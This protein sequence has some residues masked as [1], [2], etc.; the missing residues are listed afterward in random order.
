[1]TPWNLIAQ[2]QKPNQSIQPKLY[3]NVQNFTFTYLIGGVGIGLFLSVIFI[4]RRRRVTG[5]LTLYICLMTLCWFFVSQHIRYLI[6][7]LPEVCILAGFSFSRSL[8]L[9]DK[10]KSRLLTM[11]CFGAVSLQPVMLA[12][13]IL[14]LPVRGKPAQEALSLGLAPT[15][16]SL[17]EIIEEFS[18]E[19]RE[20]HLRSSAANYP[21]IEWINVNT[22]KNEGVVLFDDVFG[23]NLNR[24]YLWG[25]RGHS[26]YIPYD[27]LRSGKE[28]TSWFRKHGIVYALCNFQGTASNSELPSSDVLEVQSL[29]LTWYANRAVGQD[30]QFLIAD[31]FRSGGWNVVYVKQGVAVVKMEE[32]K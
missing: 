20:K 1:M 4:T 12:C 28:L 3:T 7:I 10:R 29:L 8:E 26:S 25:D 5:Y 15:A 22:G 6:P 13:G 17:P 24:P 30:W 19:G 16:L 31:G 27:S 32:T 23:Y 2:Y 11:I 9:W 18:A 21:A 14:F